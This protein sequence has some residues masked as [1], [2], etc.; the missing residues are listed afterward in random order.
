MLEN[1]KQSKQFTSWEIFL[2]GALAKAIATIL[3]Y[4]L[5]VAQSR[6]RAIA[7]KD[8]EE[9]KKKPKKM[10]IQKKKNK[11]RLKK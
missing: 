2:L 7:R 11:K 4:P 6:L 5:Q 9:R 1:Y 10:K 3:T 8:E